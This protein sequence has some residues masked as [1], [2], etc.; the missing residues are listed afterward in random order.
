MQLV[1]RGLVVSAFAAYGAAVGPVT[2]NNTVVIGAAR[3]SFLGPRL[4]RLEFSATPAAPAFD[5]SPTTA[6]VGRAAFAAFSGFSVSAVNATAF[7][8]ETADL[9][10]SYDAVPALSC[11]TAAS[12]TAGGAKRVPEYP[13]GTAAS[14]AA[15]CCSLCGEL[16]TCRYWVFDTASPFCWLLE[17]F[18]VSSPSPTRLLGAVVRG[19]TAESLRVDAPGI[20]VSWV[21]GLPQ[22]SNLNGTSTSLDCYISPQ[23]CFDAYQGSWEQPG[24]LARAGWTLTDDSASLRFGGPAPTSWPPQWEAPVRDATDWYF[25]AYGSDYIGALG[26]WRTLSGPPELPP[27]AILG[28]WWSQN[29]PFTDVPGDPDN[30]ESRILAGYGN[31]SLPL[32]AV[33]LDMDWHRRITCN[34]ADVSWGSYDWNSSKLPAQTTLYAHLAYGDI[35]CCPLSSCAAAFP[36]DA[37]GLQARLHSNANLV[38]HPLALVLNLHPQSGVYACEDRYG[39]V[40][41]ALGIDARTN[42][43]ILCDFGNTS[44]AAAVFDIYLNPTPLSGVD[45]YWTDFGGCVL[46]LPPTG[47]P[48]PTPAP[49]PAWPNNTYTGRPLLWTNAVFGSQQARIGRRPWLLSRFGGLGA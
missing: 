29:F 35:R 14:S 2:L 22:P 36:G 30:F 33:S 18:A 23:L 31:F 5:D 42:E 39:A 1:L 28:P 49:P 16:Q 21:P 44:Q 34:G 20:G 45:G 27:R 26:E 13:N 25:H 7:R 32:T 24:L 4:V 48:S 19:F 47:T 46:G 11:G 38:G 17:S 41:T 3:F 15:S 40:A 10:V 6:I 12:A 43:T 8:L 9:S 37:Q